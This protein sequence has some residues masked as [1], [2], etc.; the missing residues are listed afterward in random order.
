M[1][2]TR[3]H[4]TIK[5]ELGQGSFGADGNDTFEVSGL[6]ATASIEKT[7][8]VDMTWLSLRVFGLPLEVMNKLT[9]LGKPLVDGRHNKITVSAGDDESGLAVVF[10]GTIS[11]AWVDPRNAPQVAFIVSAFSGL[12]DALKPVP[13][14]SYK[15]SVDAALVVSGIAQQAGYRMENSGVSVQTTDPYL[16]GTTLQQLQKIARTGNFNCVIDNDAIAIWPIDGSRDGEEL[17][18]SPDTGLV[19]Y[20]MRTENGVELTALFNPSVV[21]GSVVTIESSLTPAN[22][23]WTVFRVVHDLEAETPNGKWFTTLEC[24]KL[25]QEV[26]IG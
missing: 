21:F 11:E 7:G 6:R 26:A 1:T 4:I 5:F 17:L 3:R 2:L 9:L 12:I 24:S 22:G 16:T 25:G 14:V 23:R 13:P 10:V 20:P 19:G 18:F 8:G 15:G